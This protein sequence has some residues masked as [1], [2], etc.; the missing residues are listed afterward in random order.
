MSLIALVS[1]VNRRLYRA[2]GG[3]LGG[4]IRGAPIL[5]LTATGR[6]SGKP[7]TV[8]LLYLRDGEDLV[9]VASNGGSPRNPAWYRNVEA[10]PEVEIEV[11]R[12]RE[13]RRART[14]TPEQRARLWPE[15]VH[16][17][18]SYESYQRKTSREIP[19]VVLSASGGGPA[20][21]DRATS[22]PSG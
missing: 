6:S 21:T 11:G 13:Q 5:L 2:S 15:L 3:K 19:L 22:R 12:E 20:R 17:Y 9:V 8:P 1:G 18:P 7:R 10:S 16:L 14:A 4:S